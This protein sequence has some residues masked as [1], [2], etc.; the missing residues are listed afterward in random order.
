MSAIT[1]LQEDY[2]LIYI[3]IGGKYGIPSDQ[4]YRTEVE[5][6]TLPL[7]PRPNNKLHSQI[8]M[9]SNQANYCLLRSQETLFFICFLLVSNCLECLSNCVKLSSVPF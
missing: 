4:V 7:H 2:N 1:F 3:R 5:R 9:F 6:G 8:G